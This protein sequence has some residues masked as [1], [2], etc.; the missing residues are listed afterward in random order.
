MIKVS[1]YIVDFLLKNQIDKCFTVT[2]GGAMHLN[3]SF[4][5][6]TN[7]T[8]IYCHHEQACAMAAEGYTRVSGIPAIVSVTSGPGTT[9]ALTGVLGAWLDSLPM[10]ILSGQMQLNTTLK[11]TPLPLRQLGFQEFNIIDS[12]KCM[13]KYAEMVTDAKYIAYHLE[14]ALFLAESARKGP[15][16]LDIPLNIQSE[17]VD[18]NDLVHFTF[19]SETKEHFV[20]RKTIS[21]IYTKINASNKPVILAGY[22]VRMSDAYEEFLEVVSALK[23]PVLTEWNSNDL[24]WNDH[25]YFGGRPGTIGDRG[26]NFVLQN[27]DFVLAVGCQFTLRQ[28]SYAWTNF[29]KNAYKVAVSADKNELIK[30]TVKIDFPVES[31]IKSFLSEMINQKSLVANRTENTKWNKWCNNLNNKYPV[32]LEKH[33]NTESPLSVYA[34]VGTL[35]NLL[36]SNDTIVLANGAACVVGLQATKIKQN[37]RI[38]TNAGASSM[39]Y[40]LTA[41][42]GACYAKQ[43]K[44]R[45][46][47]IEGDGSIQMNLQELQTV[48]HNNLNVKIFW[49]NNDGY[50]SIKQTQNLM[51][52][53]KEVG[54]C[55]ANKNSGISF[56]SAEKIA[57]AYNLPYYKIENTSD[58]Q[59]VLEDVLN[60]E[61]PSICEVITNPNEIF[62]PKLQSKLLENGKFFTPS[63]EDMYPFLPEEEM[64]ENIF[65]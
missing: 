29:A 44:D 2:G 58:L 14:K 1:D 12:V 3:D 21:D 15:V 25:E 24:I 50:H 63:L 27:A 16:W 17:L 59:F 54:F 49:I 48:V 60:N 26:G 45:V 9:N 43:P 34:F 57:Y 56:P 10:I 37:Q 53:A 46:I 47:C 35:S 18:E 39:G 52:K 4:G 32:V 6:N 28:I 33:Y 55:G 65:E 19:E 31:N 36:S 62:E 5:H 23:I 51:F 38:F 20:N 40:G 61:G 30:A 22:E 41:S 11:S 7:V 8:N 13:T 42:I 64:K